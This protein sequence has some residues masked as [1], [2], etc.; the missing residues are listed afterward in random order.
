MQPIG[1]GLL[2]P[3][4]SA[5]KFSAFTGLEEAIAVKYSCHWAYPQNPLGKGV[6]GFVGFF[7]EESSISKQLEENLMYSL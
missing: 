2:P 5:K 6:A 7:R 1:C 4:D 3:G